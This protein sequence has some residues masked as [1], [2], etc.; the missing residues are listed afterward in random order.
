MN[1][2]PQWIHCIPLELSLSKDSSLDGDIS[3]SIPLPQGALF[4]LQHSQLLNDTTPISCGARIL[5]TWPDKSVKWI[6]LTFFAPASAFEI[7]L[8]KTQ[9]KFVISQNKRSESQ[10]I[11]NSL[12]YSQS[13]NQTKVNNVHHIF[14]LDNANG[15]FSLKSKMKNK[16]EQESVKGRLIFKDASKLGCA[17]SSCNVQVLEVP[18]LLDG[19]IFALQ[20]DVD[21]DYTDTSQN[22][23]SLIHAKNIFSFTA[24]QDAIKLD[25]TL[26]NPK[27]AKHSG[28]SWDLGDPNSFNF[29]ELSVNFY[30]EEICPVSYRLTP[31]NEWQTPAQFPITITQHSS[32]GDNWQ[33]PVHVNHQQKIP[34]E[35]KGYNV[36]SQSAVIETGLRATPH[37]HFAHTFNVTVVQFWQ[38]FPSAIGINQDSISVGFFPEQINSNYE[39]QGGEKS[40]H[41]LWFSAN[42]D[43]N[44]LDW[45]HVTRSIKPNVAQYANSDLPLYTEYAKQDSELQLLINNGLCSDNNF[46][47]KREKLDEY[48]WRNFGDLYADHETAEHD[49]DAIFVSHYNNQ[50]D[51]IYGFLRQFL[52]N[53]DRRWYALADDLAK[54]VKDIDIYHTTDDKSEYNGG[55][56]WHTD[57]YLQAFTSS[58]RSYSK[59]QSKGAYQD[60]AGGGGPGGQHCYTSG[61]TLYYL[62]TGDEAAKQAVITLTNWITYVYEGGNTCFELLLALKNRNVLGLKNHFSGQYPLDRGTANY[63][64]A[65][66]DSY[67]L[68]SDTTLLHAVEHVICHTVH[69]DEDVS[70]RN[71]ENVEETWFYTVFLQSVVR[72]LDI[73]RAA[74]DFNQAFYYARDCLLNYADWMQVKEYM[75]LDKP[76]ILEYPNDTWTAQDLRKAHVLSA[77][78]FYSNKSAEQYLNTALTIENQVAS[79]LAQSKTKTY[80]RIMVLLMQNDG[81]TRYFKEAELIHELSLRKKDWSTPSYEKGSFTTQLLKAFS[82]RLLSVSIADEVNWLKKRLR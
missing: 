69:P 45:T 3:T 19:S 72:Y 41:T 59:H 61:L 5:A 79:R 23:H 33:S 47:E 71:L 29:S 80:T 43:K 77:A 36:S 51:P 26:H 10:S 76:D 75:Y 63:L 32:G 64:N 81:P 15:N 31:D 13:E 74:E 44:A 35:I 28:G 70:S 18:N 40:T 17:I 46:F 27:S 78:Y 25:V 68:T 55:M 37:V 8:P 21:I 11:S 30:R 49:G 82:K 48:G 2:N 34:F 57:H 42:E 1:N 56:F 66:L 9:F 38:K 62:L 73:K 22:T 4:D 39:L 65:L 20:L 24:D 6:H 50:Y 52:L 12:V 54:H 16:F 53:G 60:H 7:K 14:T 67:I 58:H